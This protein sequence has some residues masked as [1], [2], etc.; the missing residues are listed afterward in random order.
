MPIKSRDACHRVLNLRLVDVSLCPTIR[1]PF[2]VI[3]EGLVLKNSRSDRIRTY[4]PLVPNQTDEP[5][6][7]NKNKGIPDPPNSVT[8]MVT[9]GCEL[10]SN[11]DPSMAYQWSRLCELFEACNDSQRA[12]I[13]TVAETMV[14]QKKRS[15]CYDKTRTNLVFSTPHIYTGKQYR[16]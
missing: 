1:K 7:P 14:C 12:A 3:T 4:D 13:L 16:G 6:K 5:T 11:P 2:D 10:A 9:L 8:S 15:R